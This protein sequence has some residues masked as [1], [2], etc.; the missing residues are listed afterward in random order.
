V[1]DDD[2]RPVCF[3]AMPFGTKRVANAREGA[4][5][6]VDFD[7][8]WDKAYRPAIDDAGYTPVR[9]D[10][11]TGSVIIKDMVERLAYA[12]MVLAD[13]SLQNG[14]V[15]YEVGL[16]HAARDTGCV[17]FAA[18]WSQRLFDI[19]QFTTVT[20]PLAQGAVT[21]AEAAVIRKI[22]TEAI[23]NLGSSKTPW[24]EYVDDPK[25][26]WS[27]GDQTV[28]RKEAARLSAFQA[29]LQA[30]RLEPDAEERK[31]KIRERAEAMKGTPALKLP[32]AVV[33][34]ILHIRDHL[35]DWT[36]LLDFIGELDEDVAGMEFI[37]E[38]RLLALGKTGDNAAAIAHMM[39]LIENRGPTPERL[40]IVGGR[41]KRLWREAR[42]ARIAAQK[43]R[44][45]PDERRLLKQSFE[46]YHRGMMLDF[47]EYYCSGNVPP[48]L[49]ARGEDGDVE[50]AR[51]IDHLVV[52]A[53]NRAIELGQDDEWTRPTLLGAAFRARDEKLAE[54][55][56]DRIAEEGTSKWKL[57]T[58]IDDMEDLITL[59]DDPDQTAILEEILDQLVEIEGDS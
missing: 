47:N 3:I 21:D 5:K 11:D 39:T 42:K 10:F 23:D 59:V 57:K 17:L 55:L 29:D 37:E 15:Y 8:L 54:D 18:E 30:I 44:P 28:F 49:L 9:A 14:N 32:Q 41:Y 51:M 46:H 31:K 2:L 24:Y 25:R 6:E 20:F 19:K 36:A 4:P 52:A 43:T 7:A 27:G 40:G 16:R 58:T 56:I 26:G 34:M 22:V 50:R 35:E 45:S 13:V 12:D 1:P 38:Q 33:E 48:L 53:C